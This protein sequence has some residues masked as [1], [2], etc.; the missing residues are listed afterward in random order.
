MSLGWTEL[1][2]IVIFYTLIN[3][4]TDI[5]LSL[6]SSGLE[7]WSINQ[8]SICGN[9]ESKVF[10]SIKFLGEIVNNWPND[11]LVTM[12]TKLLNFVNNYY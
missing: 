6:I 9:P 10:K 1:H 7:F 2:L 11:L 5:F 3:N 4:Q 8:T 12:Y